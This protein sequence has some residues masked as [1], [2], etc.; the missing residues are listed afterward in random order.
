[1]MQ[2][3]VHYQCTFYKSCS[4]Y[5]S[6]ST[7]HYGNAFVGHRRPVSHRS[8]RD[9][10]PRAGSHRARRGHRAGRHPVRRPGTAGPHAE[11][12]QRRSAFGA[13]RRK[14]RVQHRRGTRVHGSQPDRPPRPRPCRSGRH[15]QGLA[16][17]PRAGRLRGRQP[18][19]GRLLHPLSTPRNF[20][21]LRRRRTSGE[22]LGI[23][24]K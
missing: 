7:G 9:R 8:R 21:T 1:M 19:Q 24:L 11:P 20:R 17:R 4:F 10:L 16:D 13:R 3:H 6:S 22:K 12:G 15:V 18:C 2:A 14:L 23:V 5:P